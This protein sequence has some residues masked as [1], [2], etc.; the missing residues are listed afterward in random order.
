[1]INLLFSDANC[2]VSLHFEGQFAARTDIIAEICE[3]SQIPL[4]NNPG[5]WKGCALIC[6]DIH[7]AQTIATYMDYLIRHSLPIL[8]RHGLLSPR[9]MLMS[10]VDRL[11]AQA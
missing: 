1:M 2:E 4:R 9:L 3:T 11:C 10:E 6:K 5:A 7:D 8:F